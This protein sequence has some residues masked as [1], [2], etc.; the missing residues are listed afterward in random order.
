MLC[1]IV[2]NAHVNIRNKMDISNETGL[3]VIPHRTEYYDSLSKVLRDN[4]SI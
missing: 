4:L 3:N 1:F 2:K